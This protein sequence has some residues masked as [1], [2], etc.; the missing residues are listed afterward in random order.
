MSKIIERTK[1]WL[2]L[3]SGENFLKKEEYCATRDIF[4]AR[5]DKNRS[6]LES[7]D[8]SNLEIIYPLIAVIGEIGNNSFDHNLGK[9]RDMAGIFFEIDFKNKIVVLADRGQGIFSSIKKVALTVK[10]D[11]GAI[12]IAFTKKI[13][14]RYPEKRGNGLK[15]VVKVAQKLDIDFFLQSGRASALINKKSGL[16]FNQEEKNIKGVLTII[17][18]DY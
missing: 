8:S 2:E 5:L 10:D 9:W 13:S 18:Y 7:T 11:L 15:F 1:K 16:E 17:K 14:G 3:K 6:I 4:Q 12:K